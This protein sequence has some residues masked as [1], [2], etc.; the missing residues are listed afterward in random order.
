METSVTIGWVL[1]VLSVITL[2]VGGTL[3]ILRKPIAIKDME[4]VGYPPDIL[5]QFGVMNILIGAAT[6]IPA[7][8]FIG[9]ILATGWMGGTIAAHVRIKDKFVI[10]TI[11][12][13][14]IW[15]GFGLRHP[16]EMHSLLGF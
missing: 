14:L 10:Q 7:T 3:N 9:V 5:V 12:P 11:I 16:L 6:L 13:I 2:F 8:S 15:I 4:Q 1:S